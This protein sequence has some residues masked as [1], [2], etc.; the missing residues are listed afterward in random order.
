MQ[1]TMNSNEIQCPHC[2]KSFDFSSILKGQQEQWKKQYDLD[3]EQEL[4]RQ[5]EK[6][7][8]EL[9]KDA[10]KTAQEKASQETADLK[11]KVQDAEKKTR[12]VL[13]KLKTEKE[14]MNTALGKEYEKKVKAMEADH[15]QK[16]EEKNKLLTRVQENLKKAQRHADQVSQQ[17]AGEVYEDIF[18]SFLRAAYR[19]DDIE[20]TETGKNGADF[21]QIVK[22]KSQKEI[23]SILWETKNTST[24]DGTKWIAKLRK[25]MAAKNATIGVLVCKTLPKGADPVQEVDGIFILQDTVAQEVSRV[26]RHIVVTM[27]RSKASQAVQSARVQEIYAYL[28][29][30]RFRQVLTH[31]SM[32]IENGR[33]AVDK[34]RVAAEK[35]FRARE[36]MFEDISGFRNTIIVD[37]NLPHED[38]EISDG[39]IMKVQDVNTIDAEFE[40]SENLQVQ[41]H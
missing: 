39:E 38:S 29:G 20:R 12:E 15:L 5:M 40:S 30:S 7:L 16:L 28:T 41:E 1:T 37:L 33:K 31:F 17:L 22:S 27:H 14:N 35:N 18:E 13:E 34:E 25:D 26:I 11:Q 21:F 8:K 36:K 23:G 4:N 2:R 3:K 24:Y 9:E 19:F 6:K 32:F 10:L